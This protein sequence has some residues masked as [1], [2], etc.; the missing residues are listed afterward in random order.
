MLVNKIY[1]GN[2]DGRNGGGGGGSFNAGTNQSNQA[3][4]HA[5]QG[6]VLVEKY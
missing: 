3:G 6:K 4:V 5:G 2:S 1:G